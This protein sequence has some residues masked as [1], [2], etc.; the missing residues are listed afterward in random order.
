MLVATGVK[1]CVQRAQVAC[2]GGGPQTPAHGPGHTG[3][4][5]RATW[6]IYGLAGKK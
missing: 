6:F 3:I 1:V 5:N 2:G 4:E